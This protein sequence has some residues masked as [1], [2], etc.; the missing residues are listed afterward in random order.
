MLVGMQTEPLLNLDLP[1]I[2]KLK[3]GKVREIF[4]LGHAFLL[5][6]TD[7]ISAFDCV[8]PNGIPRKGEVLT[9][10]SHF[11][12]ERFRPIVPNHLLAG[13]RDPLPEA[14]K[15]HAARLERR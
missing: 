2:P 7:R 10:L 1:G 9:Q 13:A 5:V 11:W 12:F 4:D 3:S 6:A 8:M 15:P 14:L